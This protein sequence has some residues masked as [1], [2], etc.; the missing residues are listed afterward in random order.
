MP[1]RVARSP[2]G[3]LACTLS[4]STWPLQTAI[5]MLPV[6]TRKNST[7]RGTSFPLKQDVT[8]VK[9]GA[10]AQSLSLSL[11]S[12]ILGKRST[13][14]ITHL[15]ALP[16]TPTSEVVDIFHHV[17]A[18]L[19]KNDNGLIHSS[20]WDILGTVIDVYRYAYFLLQVIIG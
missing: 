1:L 3:L 15:L 8:Q 14:D 7:L 9:S 2:N 17:L 18:V 19:D 12:A 10:F 6:P 20:I 13:A 4:S 5:H 16:S 11:I